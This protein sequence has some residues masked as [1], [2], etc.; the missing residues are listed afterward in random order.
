MIICGLLP[1]YFAGVLLRSMLTMLTTPS[2][3]TFITAFYSLFCIFILLGMGWLWRL[4]GKPFLSG[5]ATAAI[6]ILAAGLITTAGYLSGP[7]F[8]NSYLFKTP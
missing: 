2:S 4:M 7:L 1:I 8:A 6:I 3:I 5:V